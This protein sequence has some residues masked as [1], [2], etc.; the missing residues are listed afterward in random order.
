G[1]RGEIIHVLP[2][3]AAIHNPRD[4]QPTDAPVVNGTKVYPSSYGSGNLTDHTGPEISNASFRAI[5]WNESV[6]NSTATSS[7]ATIWSHIDSFISAFP[8]NANYG[9]AT[10]ATT[11]DY[12][13]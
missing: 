4:M 2:T 6:A 9:T 5:Y 11:A 8:N 10:T 7:G 12:T 3:P 1:D 13:I